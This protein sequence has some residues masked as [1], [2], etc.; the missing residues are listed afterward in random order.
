MTASA[1]ANGSNFACYH[2]G[3]IYYFGVSGSKVNYAKAKF[4]LEK[5]VAED[6]DYEHL[7]DEAIKRAQ[8]WIARC[9]RFI[10][11]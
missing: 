5:A 8:R 11:T 9:N 2:L 4:W 3:R 6:G 10:D 1:A 7:D